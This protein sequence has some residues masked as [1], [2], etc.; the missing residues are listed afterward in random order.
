MGRAAA[1]AAAKRALLVGVGGG[2]ALRCAPPITTAPIGF[3]SPSASL[4]CERALLFALAASADAAL[5]FAS[6][7]F[8]MAATLEP[9]FGS[10]GGPAAGGLPGAGGRAGASA[11]APA[12]E[13]PP[14]LGV[15][16]AVS[17]LAQ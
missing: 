2:V 6:K 5:A 1:A 13:W 4:S 15:R 11:F 12:A 9:P 16:V 10:G 7:A 8:A 3:T 14:G 17:P